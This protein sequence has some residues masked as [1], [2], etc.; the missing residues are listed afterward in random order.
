MIE[1]ILEPQSRPLFILCMFGTDTLT[2][3][4]HS[5]ICSFIGLFL[6]TPFDPSQILN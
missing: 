5:S 3:H 6:G 4:D 1:P 2:E